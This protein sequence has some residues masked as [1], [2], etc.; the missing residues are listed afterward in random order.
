MKRGRKNAAAEPGSYMEIPTEDQG[1]IGRGRD[2]DQ[3]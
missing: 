1:E 3:A 2:E